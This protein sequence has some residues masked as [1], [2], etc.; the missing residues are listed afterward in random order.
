MRPRNVGL[1]RLALQALLDAAR[2]GTSVVR[3]R[4]LG[5]GLSALTDLV[6]LRLA[7]GT[8]E[9]VVLRKQRPEGRYGAPEVTQ[10]EFRTLVTLHS[11][12]VPVP[13]PLCVDAEGRFFGQ[14]ALLTAY[15][16]RPLIEPRQLSTWLSDLATALAAIHR[17]TPATHDLSYLPSEGTDQIRVAVESGPRP[18]IASDELA[19]EVSAA[20]RRGLGKVA[21]IGP[22]F[23]HRDYHPGNVVWRRGRLTAVV[24]WTKAQVGDPRIDVGQCRVEIAMLH[25]QD[26]ADEF[27]AAYEEDTGP[28]LDLWFFDLLRGLL[29]LTF[30]KEYLVGYAELGMTDSTGKRAE[31]RTRE[32][33]ERALERASGG[34]RPTAK[35]Q[36]PT[37][38]GQQR[39]G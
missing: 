6:E 7:D 39:R 4:K 29:A 21:A 35:S 14:P 34:E 27:L 8:R 9:R 15:A 20:L 37:A 24:D 23:I 25:G 22:T 17:I 16:G 1:N 28:V 31:S 18:E 38:N 33:L 32:F 19:L 2:P 13:E 12:G 36:E 5:G 11:A 3:T 26:A 10:R 30:W